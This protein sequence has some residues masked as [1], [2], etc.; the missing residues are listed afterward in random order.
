M[1]DTKE[2]HQTTKEKKSK[3]EVQINIKSS[4]KKFKMVI[5]TYLLIIILMSMD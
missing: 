2:N 3:R 4:G 5:N 1:Y